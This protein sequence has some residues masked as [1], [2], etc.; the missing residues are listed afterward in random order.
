MGALRRLGV[1]RLGLGRLS[2]GSRWSG[3]GLSWRRRV[4]AQPCPGRFRRVRRSGSFFPDGAFK[5]LDPFQEGGGARVCGRGGK[6]D[7]RHFQGHPRVDRISHF[8]QG[9]AHRLHGPDEERQGHLPR[10]LSELLG[11]GAR[12]QDQ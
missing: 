5:A 11:S 9:L 3:L 8:D 12:Q 4:C 10:R 2:N 6:A 7:E 1:C